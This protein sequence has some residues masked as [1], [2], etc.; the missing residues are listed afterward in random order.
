VSKPED[1][2]EDEPAKIPDPNAE[3]PAGWLEDEEVKYLLEFLID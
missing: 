1:W 2:D 3:M